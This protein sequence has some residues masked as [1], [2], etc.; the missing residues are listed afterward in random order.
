MRLNCFILD[1]NAMRGMQVNYV[2]ATST[3]ANCGHVQ[4]EAHVMIKLIIFSVNAWMD[5][6]A[7]F[8][9]MILMSAA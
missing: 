7:D 3:S 9:Q 1:A 6:Q 4:M 8:A 5:S 2:R